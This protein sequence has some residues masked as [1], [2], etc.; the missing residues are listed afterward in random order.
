MQ[1]IKKSS[2]P[3]DCPVFSKYE[4]RINELSRTI[5]GDK[6][7]SEKIDSAQ[8]LLRIISFL[9]SCP[10]YDGIREDCFNCQFTLNLKREMAELIVKAAEVP[11]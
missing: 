10:H 3:I 7:L 5:L 1:R 6:P 8:E 4:E 9:S 2:V 11:P